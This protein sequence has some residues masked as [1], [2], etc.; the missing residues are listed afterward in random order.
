MLTLP[1]RGL[2]LLAPALMIVMLSSLFGGCDKTADETKAKPAGPVPATF[3]NDVGMSFKLV[4]AGE[5]EIGSPET[6]GGRDIDEAQHKVTLKRFYIATTEVTQAQ[7]EQLMGNNPSKFVGKDQ[8]VDGVTRAQARA[9]ATK[10]SA[11]DGKK[12]RLPTEAE[13][14]V[15]CRAGTTTPYNVGDVLTAGTANIREKSTTVALGLKQNWRQKT[16]KV[17]S[18]EPNA[19]GIHDMH[20][21]V[22][23]WTDDDYAPKARSADAAPDA[24]PAQGVLRGG[25]WNFRPS[26]ARCATRFS[27][28]PDKGYDVNGF[29]LVAEAD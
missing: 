22:W 19:W 28:D 24:G 12:Y 8:P 29:R 9:F 23:E 13:W 2:S 26:A 17:G 1:V 27:L 14:E 7:Y 21:N 16:I 20:G 4:K 3:D 10:L 25:A 5:Y 6:E 18:F 11:K 15:A